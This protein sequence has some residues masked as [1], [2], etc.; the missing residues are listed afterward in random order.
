MKGS[1]KARLTIDL[2]YVLYIVVRLER[3]LQKILNTVF[4]LIYPY[5]RACEELKT[6]QQMS[7]GRLNCVVRF[8]AN[9]E[10][11]PTYNALKAATAI[12]IPIGRLK[13]IVLHFQRYHI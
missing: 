12:T 8:S 10:I 1:C 2:R 9:P 7:H 5:V 11:K 4:K 3:H 13:I 6:T